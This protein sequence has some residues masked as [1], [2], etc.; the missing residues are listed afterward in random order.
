MNPSD[1]LLEKAE[2]SF[3]AAELLLH[4]GDADFAASRAYYGCFYI[5]Q[6]LLLDKDL[7]FSS[8]GQVLAQY[9][10]HF[11]KTRLLD[12]AFHRLLDRTFELRQV[13]DYEATI[14]I[15]REVVFEV[16]RQGRNFLEAASG[17]L[18]GDKGLDAD[19]ENA[20]S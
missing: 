17:F 13:A 15:N 18:A 19:G 4:E 7:E 10:L 6:A 1:L 2:R 9:G 5:A 3:R 16:I 11:S 14:V 12:P 8:H 20:E